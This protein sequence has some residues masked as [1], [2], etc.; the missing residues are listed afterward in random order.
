MKPECSL[1]FRKNVPP[2]PI[3]SQNNSVHVTKLL[4]KIHFNIILHLC[5]RLPSGI[6]PPGLRQILFM[7]S[8][9]CYIF[10]TSHSIDCIILIMF[11]KEHRL[12]SSTLRNCLQSPVT[13]F[14]LGSNNI[15]TLF[16][17]TLFLCG[18][19]LRF[20]CL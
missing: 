14:P 10:R 5:L 9:M 8:S 6:F 19:K 13:F 15:S 18:D 12:R 4:F 11:D 20:A 17:Y 7:Y 2:G 1:P 16:L 3:L